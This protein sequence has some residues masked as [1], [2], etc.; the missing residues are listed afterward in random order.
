MRPPPPPPTRTVYS[1]G[2]RPRTVYSRR[3]SPTYYHDSYDPEPYDGSYE[4]PVT[5]APTVTKVADR[6]DESFHDGL[7]AGRAEAVVIVGGAALLY[8]NW[9]EGEG[10]FEEEGEDGVAVTTVSYEEELEATRR[11]IGELEA[12]HGS[13]DPLVCAI[14]LPLSGMYVGSSAED[15]DGDQDV[16]TLLEFEKDGTLTGRGFDS[17]DGPYAIQEG[18]WSVAEGRLGGGRV[19]WIE[20]YEDGFEVAL[21]GQI[22]DDGVIRAL[23]ASD[24]DVS[25]SVD[26]TL[27]K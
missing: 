27:E 3:P 2:G 9:R 15:D 25:G 5:A 17:E 16:R 20:R 8:R 4:E 6:R 18:R 21:R 24:R 26:L 19:A 13:A 7:M 12:E 11:L 22:R 1:R 23:W 10:R 14:Q